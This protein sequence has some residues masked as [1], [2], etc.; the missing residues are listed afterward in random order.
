M[1]SR[2]NERKN[3]AIRIDPRVALFYNRRGLFYTEKNN[4]EFAV[5]DFDEAIRLPR[6]GLAAP[7]VKGAMVDYDEAIRLDPRSANARLFRSSLFRNAANHDRAIDDLSEA[8][9]LDPSVAL[10]HTRRGLSYYAKHDYRRAI[11]DFTEALPINPNSVN[12]IWGRGQANAYAGYKGTRHRR[13]LRSDPD[14]AARAARLYRPGAGVPIPR[15]P[16]PRHRRL[17]RIPAPQPGG[18]ERLLRARQFVSRK[19]ELD[20]AI[21]DNS[22]AIRL[23][24]RFSFAYHDRGVARRMNGDREQA[25]SDFR[26]AARLSSATAGPSRAALESHSVG[27]PKTEPGAQKRGVLD[28]LK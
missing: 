22:E 16:R 6:R 10:F 27:E 17:Q 4:Y 21:A 19:G 7:A 8:I 13:L 26:Q 25:I 23:D 20:R 5:D 14:R 18:F 12:V 1:V 3:S 9:H 2:A 24:P 28:L 15:R 11:A